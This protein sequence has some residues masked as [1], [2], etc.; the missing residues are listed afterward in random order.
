MRGKTVEWWLR[1]A[2]ELPEQITPNQWQTTPP[3][4]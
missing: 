1:M 2:G 4:P 3:I